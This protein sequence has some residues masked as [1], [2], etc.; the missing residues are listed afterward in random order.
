MNEKWNIELRNDFLRVNKRLLR[1]DVLEHSADKKLAISAGQLERILVLGR[2]SILHSIEESH[3]RRKLNQPDLSDI[4]RPSIYTVHLALPDQTDGD[5]GVVFTEHG[6]HKY[7]NV[8]D[9]PRLSIDDIQD[10]FRGHWSAVEKAGFVPEVR[11]TS[12]KLYGGAWL[13]LRDTPQDD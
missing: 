3:E 2:I 6:Y 1:A 7:D 4:V 12:G 5:M 8:P 10:R 9:N 11:K 13:L